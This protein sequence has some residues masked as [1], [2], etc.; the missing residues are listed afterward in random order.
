MGNLLHQLICNNYF[1]L[2]II[3]KSVIMKLALILSAIISAIQG[4]PINPSLSPI[5]LGESNIT[6]NNT[7]STVSSIMLPAIS[8]SKVIIKPTKS[9]DHMMQSVDNSTTIMPDT[10]NMSCFNHKYKINKLNATIIRQHLN[11]MMMNETKYT[12]EF[13][14]MS[15]SSADNGLWCGLSISRDNI[16]NQYTVSYDAFNK[17]SCEERKESKI[18]CNGNST[19]TK[20][21]ACCDGNNPLADD[22]CNNFIIEQVNDSNN[23]CMANNS[24]ECYQLASVAPV[25]ISTTLPTTKCGSEKI[26][27]MLELCLLMLASTILPLNN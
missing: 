10:K 1:F 27:S 18:I 15:N 7:V 2:Q 13:P 20:T 16:Y 5:S 17:S 24:S 25:T 4:T 22:N 21:I 23:T 6:S 9:S 11:Q 19:C 8:S 12:K 14:E 26:A 3:I